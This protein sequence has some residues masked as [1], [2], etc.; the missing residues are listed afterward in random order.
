MN[1]RRNFAKKTVLAGVGITLA[2]TLSFG[3]IK[4]LTTDKLKLAF[5]GVGLRGTNHLQ[6]ALLRK[7]VEITAICDIDPKRIDIALGKIK[8]AGFKNP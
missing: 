4:G 1:S 7:D 6:N 5:I 2:P 3:T 8:E